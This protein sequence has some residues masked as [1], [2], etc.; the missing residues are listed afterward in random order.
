MQE[1]IKAGMVFNFGH[2]GF[3]PMIQSPD[4][5]ILIDTDEFDHHE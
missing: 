5:G 3:Y 4:Q 1:V 2:T